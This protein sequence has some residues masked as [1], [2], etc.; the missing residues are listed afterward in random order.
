METM[1]AVPSFILLFSSL[2]FSL[3]SVQQDVYEDLWSMNMDIANKTLQ[4]DFMQQMQS[5]S[6]QAERYVNFTLQDINYVREVTGMLKIMSKKVK[7]PK[8]LSDLITG[9][10]NSYKSFLDL[11]IQ[12]YFFKNAASIKPTPAMKKYLATYRQAM[13]KDPIYFAVALVPCARLWVWLANNVELP[14][15]NVYHTWQEDNKNGNPKKHYRD[16]LNKYL[17]TAEKI[18]VAKAIFRTQMQNEHDFFETS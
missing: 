7:K 12:Q 14:P 11:L 13:T 15:T 8:D 4:L 18:N 1:S 16:V 6:L 9:R 3:A 17:D 5:N 2:S 10:Y